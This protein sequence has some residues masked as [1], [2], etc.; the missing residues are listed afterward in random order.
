MQ[1]HWFVTL[2]ITFVVR[3]L[4][5]F[6]DEA[7]WELIEKDAEARIRDLVPGVFFDEFAVALLKKVLKLAREMMDDPDHMKAFLT[8]L[9]EKR[10]QDAINLMV[11]WIRQHLAV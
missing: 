8:A 9:A 3:Q 10:F 2:I 7:N 4:D 6:G 1:I 11:S 5:K